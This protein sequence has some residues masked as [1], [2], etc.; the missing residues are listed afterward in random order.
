M[1]SGYAM[2]ALT[3]LTA[4]NL[5]IAQYPTRPIRVL[6]GFPAGAV[7]DN[8]ARV[9]AHAL[10][11]GLGQPVVVENRPGGDSA[12][13]ADA[14]SRASPDGYTLAFATV[15]AMA[16]AP[17]LR[18]V[19]PYDPV[20]DF[21]HISL[22]ARG[23]FLL[24]VNPSV[25]ATTV[26]ELIAYARA[27]PGKLDYGTGNPVAL[28]ATAQLM[29][30]A[31]VSMVHIPYK[32]EAPAL[33]DLVAGRVQLMFLSSVASGLAQ[34]K[35]GKLRVIGAMLDRRS[36]LAPDVPT[37]AEA[38]VPSV[39]VRAWVGLF[40]PPKMPRDTI[41]RLSQEMN[42]ILK[43]PEI[44]EQMVRQGYEAEGSTPEE[45]E[46]YVKDQLVVWSRTIKESLI[47]QE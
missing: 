8:A 23:T 24:F 20:A 3:L 31:G 15:S 33:P 44:R 35:E 42:A 22:I 6:V 34:V 40:G 14:V 45:L 28:I 41:Q 43:R 11:Q 1:K 12:I 19:P 39:S 32:G 16:A 46:R 10:S 7:A 29:N 30:A 13:A 37:M 21:S 4:S 9:V 25:P 5:A 17:S 18:K 2:L 47:A 26:N 27:N 38:G 36:L